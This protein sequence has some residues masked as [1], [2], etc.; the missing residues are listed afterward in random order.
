[1]SY[2]RIK[3]RNGKKYA[4]EVT[5]YWDPKMKRS[6][7]KSVYLGTVEETGKIVPVGRKKLGKE[8][9]ILDFGDGFCLHQVIKQSSL[10]EPL[11]ES[12]QGKL[13]DVLPLIFYRMLTDSAL[14][15]CEKWIE[16]NVLAYLYTGAGLSS[17]QISRTLAF[18]GDEAIQRQFFE[19]YLSSMGGF[20]KTVIIDATALPNQIQSGFSAW[21]YADGGVEKQFR[22]L[23]VLD[24]IT[25]R[26]LFYRYLP[27][28]L[29][30]VSTLTQTMAELAKMGIKNSFALMDAG[31]FSESNI[32]D[33]YERNI[34]FLTRLPAGR[35]L[36][37]QLI[38]TQTSDLEQIKYASTYGTRGLFVK[39][40]PVD[41]YGH[42]GFAYLILDPARKG[43]EMNALL[44]KGIETAKEA[45]TE[46]DAIKFN[47]CGIMI[48]VSSKKIE[49]QE[50][51]SCY[52]MRQAVEQVFGFCKDDLSL[53][54]I[55]RHNESTIRGYLFMQFLTLIFFIELRE[56]LLNLCTVEQALIILRHLKCKVFDNELLISE[57][58]KK[59]KEI[60][61][62]ISVMAPTSMGI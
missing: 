8:L 17:Q 40:L 42:E 3:I 6:R 18:L 5:S 35:A 31:Y 1:M 11:I 28:N 4:Y 19:R 26:P 16:G 29:S 55:R 57:P 48:L 59:Q 25:K 47:R 9:L 41:L 2:T 12:C 32:L 38:F 50:V 49:S 56:K 54:P 20:E 33:L 51:V 23:C 27:G 61:D 43:K 34:D 58:T 53:L 60:L 39:T 62:Q 10:Y 24:C 30:D 13:R 44:V 21:G 45:G 36:Y 46:I 37:K 22:L 14:Y 52:Y 15:N 7:Q